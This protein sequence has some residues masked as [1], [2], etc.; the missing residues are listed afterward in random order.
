LKIPEDDLSS[1]DDEPPE[2]NCLYYPSQ[3][4]AATQAV[5][6]AAEWIVA[7]KKK[8]KTDEADN[9]RG[10]QRKKKQKVRIQ[11]LPSFYIAYYFGSVS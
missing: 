2:R 10:G 5:W 11:G 1:S 9:P 8:T 4:V 7:P 6:D 3:K